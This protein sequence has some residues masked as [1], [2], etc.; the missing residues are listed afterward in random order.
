[1]ASIKALK[2]EI[3]GIKERNK[4]VETDKAW[5]TSWTRRAIILLLTYI[6]MAIFFISAE[7]PRPFTNSIVPAAA[8]A[9]STLSLP[10]FK[11]MWLKWRTD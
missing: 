4:R 8:F 6:A 9:I 7:L 3:H 11:E 2:K 10:F 5:E 1:M